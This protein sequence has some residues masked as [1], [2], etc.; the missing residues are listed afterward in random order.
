MVWHLRSYAWVH[1]GY[2]EEEEKEQEQQ[3][4]FI[5]LSELWNSD[6]CQPTL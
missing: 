1:R 5:I 2:K 4:S 3:V 6:C